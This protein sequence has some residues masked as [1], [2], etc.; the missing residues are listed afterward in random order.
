MHDPLGETPRARIFQQEPKK[1]I[2]IHR[3]NEVVEVSDLRIRI[4]DTHIG[5]EFRRQAQFGR[6]GRT[7]QVL[8]H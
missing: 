6:L 7:T 4:Q 3:W 5:L 1:A 8:L 2:T